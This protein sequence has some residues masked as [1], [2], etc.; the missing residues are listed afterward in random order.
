MMLLSIKSL[1]RK[2]FKKRFY[3]AKIDVQAKVT[4]KLKSE[5]EE[6]KDQLEEKAEGEENGND[7][8]A[9]D[10]F[11]KPGGRDHHRM[12]LNGWFSLRFEH[13]DSCLLD[14]NDN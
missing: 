13:Y 6:L 9:E 11:R 10:N 8:E 4:E 5:L 1:S 3:Q 12:P 14:V 2:S 7:M